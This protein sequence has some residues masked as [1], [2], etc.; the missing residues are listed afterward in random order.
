MIVASVITV[1]LA[2]VAPSLAIPAVTKGRIPFKWRSHPVLSFPRETV[3]STN[4]PSRF[5]SRRKAAGEP[6]PSPSPPIFGESHQV[7]PRGR[8][9]LGA[10]TNGFGSGHVLERRWHSSSDRRL[11]R[12]THPN[13]ERD[14]VLL[15][16]PIDG[17]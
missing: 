4:G 12:A 5:L 6:S 3:H 14:G 17:I 11:S 9:Y 13:A 2:S 10:Q 16:R 1:L 15:P 8:C 7:W